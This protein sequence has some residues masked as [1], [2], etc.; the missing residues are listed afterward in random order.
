MPAIKTELRGI[1]ADIRAGSPAG[2][3]TEVLARL[4]RLTVPAGR[5]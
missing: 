4:E 2:A 3:L 5:P 1:V